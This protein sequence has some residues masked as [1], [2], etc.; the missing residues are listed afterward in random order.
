MMMN[1]HLSAIINVDFSVRAQASRNYVGQFCL[2]FISLISRDALEVSTG[3]DNSSRLSMCRSCA[4]INMRS[5]GDRHEQQDAQEEHEIIGTM[6]QVSA[7]I[8]PLSLSLFVA[9]REQKVR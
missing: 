5:F 2:T 7:F 3:Q 1:H 4:T 9:Q 8:T 6:R